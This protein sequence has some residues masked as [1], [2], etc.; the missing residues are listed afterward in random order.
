MARITH[1]AV[2][3]VAVL[4]GVVFISGADCFAVR[5]T[6]KPEIGLSPGATRKLLA[7][8]QYRMREKV[9]LYANKAGPFHNPSE[10]RRVVVYG[11]VAEPRLRVRC[12]LR[13]NLPRN[14][15]ASA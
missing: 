9:P 15:F 7:T 12:R 6:T 4:F 8:H 5:G 2:V 1:H 14:L 10:V 3:L 11:A 13:W